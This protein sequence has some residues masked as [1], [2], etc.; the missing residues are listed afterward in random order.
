[1]EKG[2][3]LIALVI[4]IIVLLILAG[5]S[6]VVLTGEDGILEKAKLAKER[7][8]QAEK[9]ENEILK[10]Y[11]ELLGTYGK[12]L[13]ENTTDMEAGTIVKIPSRWYTATPNEVE[14]KEGN[15]V[16]PSRR[17]TN[18]YATSDGKGNTIPVPYGFY[19]VGGTLTTGVVISD[20]QSDKN[21]YKGIEDVPTGVVYNTDGTVNKEQCELQGNQFVW[22]PCNEKDYEK[23]DFGDNYKTSG[24]WDRS[25]NS[26]EYG[27][28]RKYGGFY[29]GRYEAGTSDITLADDVKFEHTST[30]STN[31][32]GWDWQN[33]NFVSSKVRSGKITSKAGE[34]PYYH[35]D[36]TTA[37]EMTKNM[38]HTE[39]V[40]SGMV[41]GTMWDVMMK[42]VTTD[43]I[44]YSDLKN[45]SWGNYS[46][47]T[48]VTYVAG[49][50]RYLLVARD[51]SVTEKA[52]VADS[53]YYYG[54]RTTA[55]S[56]DVKRKNLYD[57]AGNLWE[58][59]MEGSYIISSDR[60]DTTYSVRGGCFNA[61]V[62]GR[63]VCFRGS[64]HISDNRTIYGFRPALY[65]M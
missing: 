29:I 45:T 44:N 50:G 33:G 32:Y 40:I 5:V 65:I 9:E 57:I 12:E 55:S 62:D 49:Q 14:T 35:A 21:K 52:T 26:A 4:T 54:I 53:N 24:D 17:I 39:Y 47:N 6:I 27:Q 25:T 34:I 16:I 36:Y 56:E 61:Q 22:I 48:S 51:G 18:V 7:S 23:V 37:L 1:M 20:H 15:V 8:E 41:T 64:G 42:F 60:I 11:E 28:I 63:P 59:T 58:W 3:T 30:G 43:P 10:Q 31:S 38:Y 19:Y 13:P 2:I 46:N